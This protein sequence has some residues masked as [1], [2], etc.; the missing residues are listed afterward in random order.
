MRTF[1]IRVVIRLTGFVF[2]A[3]KDGHSPVDDR[4]VLG[5]ADFESST[6]DVDIDHRLID[7][8]AG[9]PQVEL[10]SPK[11]CDRL[12]TAKIRRIDSTLA[13]SEDGESITTAAGV[14]R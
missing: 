12:A 10:D 2:D 11:Y 6:N 7:R 1:G 13:A 4:P 5:H 14:N 8:H 3:A 9:A